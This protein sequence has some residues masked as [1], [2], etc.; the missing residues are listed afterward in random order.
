MQLAKFY[1]DALESTLGILRTEE[2]TP[3]EGFGIAFSLG[4]AILGERQLS[5]GVK[6]LGPEMIGCTGSNPGSNI[7]WQCDFGKFT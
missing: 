7:Y 1:E 2:L 4:S 5:M 6:S 3:C